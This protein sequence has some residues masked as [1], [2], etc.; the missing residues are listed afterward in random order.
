MLLCIIIF[1]FGSLHQG[2]YTPLHTAAANNS[3]R[4]LALLISHGANVNIKANVSNDH[5]MNWWVDSNNDSY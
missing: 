2:G 3:T 5:N 1:M 4:C